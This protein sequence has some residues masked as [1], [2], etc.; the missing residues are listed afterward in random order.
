MLFE[1][2]YIQSCCVDIHLYIGAAHI[3]YRKDRTN[4]I[5]QQRNDII[6]LM[7]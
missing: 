5:R 3:I 4:Q 2:L 7:T 1:V 6:E